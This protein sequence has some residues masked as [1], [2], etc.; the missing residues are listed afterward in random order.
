[1]LTDIY[2][3]TGLFFMVVMEFTSMRDPHRVLALLKNAKG[4]EWKEWDTSTRAHFTLNAM[5]AAW[6]GIG[7]ASDQFLLFGA[8]LLLS[9]VPKKW[10]WYIRIDAAIT[11]AIILF[12]VLNHFHWKMDVWN[13]LASIL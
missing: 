3:L 9:L 1:M 11:S 13:T 6:I 2:Y 5:Y 7:A 10:A 12:M 4:K 8:V